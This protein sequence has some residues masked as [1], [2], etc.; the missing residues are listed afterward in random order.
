MEWTTLH[1]RQLSFILHLGLL[2]TG[3]LPEK[4][5]NVVISCRFYSDK[6]NENND[7][8]RAAGYTMELRDNGTYQFLL[9]P[10]QVIR[11]L[12]RIKAIKMCITLR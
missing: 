3:T 7:G 2:Q 4:V 6:A 8:Y 10:D 1:K 9:P 12:Y 11:L 5:N